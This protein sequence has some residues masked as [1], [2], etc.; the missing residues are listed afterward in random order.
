MPLP[1]LRQAEQLP[2][3]QPTKITA[4]TTGNKS[5]AVA[6]ATLASRGNGRLSFKPVVIGPHKT[7]HMPLLAQLLSYLGAQTMMALQRWWTREEQPTS[8]TWTGQSK[9]I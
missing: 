6:P 3:S 5:N 2:F 8:S 7:K 4:A 9:I 1:L